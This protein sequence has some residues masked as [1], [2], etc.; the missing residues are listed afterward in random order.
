LHGKI[1]EMHTYIVYLEAK[2][3]KPVPTS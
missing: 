2:L 3:K 1:D